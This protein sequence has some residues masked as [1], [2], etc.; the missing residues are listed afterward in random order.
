MQLLIQPFNFTSN[1]ENLHI[2]LSV[3]QSAVLSWFPLCINIIL[4]G[5]GFGITKGGQK[6]EFIKSQEGTAKVKAKE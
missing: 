4:N 6:S 3:F 5:R 1:A 2:S